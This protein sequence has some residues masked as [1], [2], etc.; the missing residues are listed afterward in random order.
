M[1]A[2]KKR[3]PCV[4]RVLGSGTPLFTLADRF[5]E[6]RGGT[7]LKR[8]DLHTWVFRVVAQPWLGNI[9]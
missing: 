5:G 2:E 9:K 3:Y 8:S 1:T 4:S 7:Y 6:V